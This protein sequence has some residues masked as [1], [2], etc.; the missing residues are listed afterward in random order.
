[1]DFIARDTYSFGGSPRSRLGLSV[2]ANARDIATLGFLS[3]YLL[4]GLEA[5]YK[6]LHTLVTNLNGSVRCFLSLTVFLA[7]VFTRNAFLRAFLSLL[8]T[9]V[10]IAPDCLP[11]QSLRVYPWAKVEALP[12]PGPL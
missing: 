4:F 10:S 12:W 2:I 11:T 1:M 9:S 8:S 6:P 3:V 7:T 5:P